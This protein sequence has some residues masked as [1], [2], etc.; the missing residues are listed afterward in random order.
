MNITWFSW[1]DINHPLAG[2]A[3]AISW[4][5]MS[6]LAENGHNVKLVTARY[7][8]STAHEVMNGVEIYRNGGTLS[9]YPKAFVLFRKKLAGWSDIVIDEMNT[10]P[11]GCAFYTRKKSAL[12]VY[13][14]ARK[15]WLFQAKFP[16]SVVGYAIE[17]LYLFTL[18]RRY[19]TILTESEST[20]QDLTKY[21]FSAKNIHVF[22]VGIG[23][24]PLQAL[25]KK[26]SLDTVLILGAL[27]PM[28]RTL[29]A[30]K[31]YELARDKNPDLTL[32]IAGDITDPYASKV[33][34]YIDNSRHVG[35]IKV[36]GRVSADERIKVMRQASVILV[37][38]IKEGWG[39]TVTEANSQG[40]PAI[41][42]NIDG[43]R[44]SIK[45]RE[46]G[47]LVA[48]GDEEALSRSIN[49]LLSDKK[50]YAVLRNNAWQL[51]K[52]YTF[53]NSY[54]DFLAAVDIETAH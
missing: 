28:K 11:F 38:S 44:D 23:L 52:Q 39:L 26:Q 24:K 1:K 3:E 35:S 10:L 5:I 19:K 51:S 54:T 33:L 6:R 18:S 29:S 15:V 22:R 49:A 25:N 30:V 37:T 40:T 12:L 14:L 32:T 31:G 21:G 42:Y 2:G 48:S 17:P 43:L 50:A 20:R 7:A 16:L 27:R 41:A 9:V 45:D 13:Q 36:L 8:G 4:E 53:D 47:I 34:K 46:T